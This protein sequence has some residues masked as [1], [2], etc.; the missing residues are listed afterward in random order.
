MMS[1]QG[2]EATVAALYRIY[3]ARGAAMPWAGHFGRDCPEPDFNGA[4]R[5][6]WTQPLAQARHA[7]RRHLAWLGAGL[8]AVV[9]GVGW[10]GWRQ[11]RPADAA[12]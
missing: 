5:L 1:T 4:A 9:I 10:W 6:L 7:V 11:R 8:A 12:S 2:Q 3:V